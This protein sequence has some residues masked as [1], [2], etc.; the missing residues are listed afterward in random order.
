DGQTVS[1]RRTIPRSGQFFST[2]AR[3]VAIGVVED[4]AGTRE[5]LPR[6]SVALGA[7]ARRRHGA[8]RLKAARAALDLEDRYSVL[9]V[10]EGVVCREMSLRP[11]PFHADRHLSLLHAR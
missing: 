7:E 1:A 4:A 3:S 2:A 11:E 9:A 10:G 5:A 8:L 6:F